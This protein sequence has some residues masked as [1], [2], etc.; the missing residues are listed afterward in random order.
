MSVTCPRFLPPQQCKRIQV[1]DDDDD[2]VQELV[3]A[4][5][6]HG[7]CPDDFKKPYEAVCTVVSNVSLETGTFV[8][9]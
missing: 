1:T 3:V 7:S 6:S 2:G 9:V 5:V 4:D 8:H